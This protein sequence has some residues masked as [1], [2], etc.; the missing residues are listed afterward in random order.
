MMPELCRYRLVQ[1][2]KG[3]RREAKF[4]FIGAWTTDHHDPVSVLGEM[5]RMEMLSKY[6][7]SLKSY[8]DD[9]NHLYIDPNPGINKVL[10]SEYPPKYLNDHIHPNSHE[11]IILYSAKVFEASP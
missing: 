2:I 11:G 5:E 10:R 3:K 1:E 6:R 8:A 7:K 9:H 4:V